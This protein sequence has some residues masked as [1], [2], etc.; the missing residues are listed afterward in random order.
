[1]KLLA[2]TTRDD[3]NSSSGG[4]TLPRTILQASR[5]ISK[6]TLPLLCCLY[7]LQGKTYNFESPDDSERRILAFQI[8]CQIS[9]LCP[10]GD[11]GHQSA[12]AI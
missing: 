10:R 1:M 5:D 2:W 6:L 4:L 9:I 8:G 11:Y 3:Y 12:E 7:A